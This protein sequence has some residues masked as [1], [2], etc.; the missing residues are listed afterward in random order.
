M[1]AGGFPS[2]R[3]NLDSTKSLSGMRVEPGNSG[4]GIRPQSRFE[5]R[6]DPRNACEPGNHEVPPWVVGGMGG[7]L[8]Q[9][10]RSIKTIPSSEPLPPPPKEY[11]PLRAIAAQG[12]ARGAEESHR[13]FVG[14]I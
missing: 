7:A 3:P 1:R 5:G 4:K 13:L 2:L 11:T 12:C 10:P 14:F 6:L 8:C 9:I